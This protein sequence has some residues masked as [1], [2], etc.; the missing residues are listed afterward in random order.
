MQVEFSGKQAKTEINI[1][2]VYDMQEKDESRIEQREKLGCNAI[3]TK[4]L[5]NPTWSSETGMVL[6]SCPKMWGVD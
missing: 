6:Q 2:G 1:W 4:V 5:V 3:S